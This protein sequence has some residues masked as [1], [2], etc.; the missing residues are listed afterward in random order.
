MTRPASFLLGSRKETSAGAQ[1]PKRRL[2]LCGEARKLR[3]ESRHATAAIQHMLLTARPCRVGRRIDVEIKRRTLLRI[4]GAGAVRRAV[5]QNDIDKVI[6][7]VNVLFHS[8]TQPTYGVRSDCARRQWKR[9]AITTGRQDASVYTK[10]GVAGKGQCP[11]LL[12]KRDQL[13]M[14]DD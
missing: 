6:V 14:K 4:R 13:E 7:G 2:A 12:D 5:R 1:A 3:V 8:V 10:G 11:E 9:P